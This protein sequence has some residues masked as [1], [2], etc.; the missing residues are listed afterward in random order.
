MSPLQDVTAVAK[1][2]DAQNRA[3][4]YRALASF[5]LDLPKRET[6][7]I[8]AEAVKGDPDA[9]EG[10]REL[11]VF[12]SEASIDDE[13]VLDEVGSDRTFLVRGVTQKGPRPPYGSLFAGETPEAPG[14]ACSA[15]R[16]CTVER[17][18]R[19]RNQPPNRPITWASSSPS[20]LRS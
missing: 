12:F 17:G 1:R 2:I 3:D 20:L 7:Q 6:L 8:M 16:R 19:C 14:R 4:Q 15:S 5:F 9:S 18:S 13:G 11:Q 10:L